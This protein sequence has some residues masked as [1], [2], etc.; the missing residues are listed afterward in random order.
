MA[1]LF[2]DNG[3]SPHYFYCHYKFPFFWHMKQ[4]ETSLIT[5]GKNS[6]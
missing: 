4:N 1:S 3:V 2:F 6:R 5:G